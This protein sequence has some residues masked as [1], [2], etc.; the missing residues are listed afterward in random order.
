MSDSSNYIPSFYFK[1]TVDGEDFGF[2]EVSGISK[3]LELEEI[4][5]GGENKFTFQL[6]TKTVKTN[7]TLKR[8]LVPED[9]KLLNWC[10]ETMDHDLSQPIQTKDVSVTLLGSKGEGLVSWTFFNS[11]PVRYLVS[12][13]KS[14]VNALAMETIEL[15][16]SYFEIRK[17]T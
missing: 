1:L 9:S 5:S 7:L 4:E 6:P 16:Y 14:D 10:S 3:E 2:Q 17:K 12:D 11:F 8:A 15:S 13:F